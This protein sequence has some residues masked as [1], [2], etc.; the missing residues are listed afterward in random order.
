M[1]RPLPVHLV[2]VPPG[3]PA[4]AVA[5]DRSDLARFPY[6]V[7][8][9]D[10]Y[11][12]LR[13][14]AASPDRVLI[15]GPQVELLFPPDLARAA[16]CRYR[17]SDH[18]FLPRDLY[19]VPDF[20]ADFLLS[21]ITAFQLDKLYFLE[22]PEPSRFRL[23]CLERSALAPLEEIFQFLPPEGEFAQQVRLTDDWHQRLHLRLGLTREGKPG[24]KQNLRPKP[25]E[26]P[27]AS[28]PPPAEELLPVVPGE[29]DAN[30]HGTGHDA[31]S[32]QMAG[33]AAVLSEPG[34]KAL[35]A[36]DPQAWFELFLRCLQGVAEPWWS[37]PVARLPRPGTDSRQHAAGPPAQPD[38][39]R[40]D[41]DLCLV[42]AI[43]RQRALLEDA[44]KNRII[45]SF[46][47]RHCPQ[48][49]CLMDPAATGGGKGPPGLGLKARWVLSCQSAEHR[50]DF[51]WAFERSREILAELEIPGL[52]PL[53]DVPDFL[54][55]MP[56]DAVR[57][58]M[59]QGTRVGADEV[60]DTIA[61]IQGE[62][63]ALPDRERSQLQ[64]AFEGGRLVEDEPPVTKPFPLDAVRNYLRLRAKD[65]PEAVFEPFAAALA[66]VAR[67]VQKG[68]RALATAYFAFL[69]DVIAFF[70]QSDFHYACIR[71][72][73]H[74][75]HTNLLQLA[76]HPD[77]RQAVRQILSLL[78]TS[79]V[80]RVN[81]LFFSP[82]IQMLV[83]RLRYESGEDLGYLLA[84]IRSLASARHGGTGPDKRDVIM[85]MLHQLLHLPMEDKLE[86]VRLLLYSSHS[87]EM[88]RLRAEVLFN[89]QAFLRT[90]R[91]DAAGFL[92][93]YR[94][95]DGWRI[96]RQI[97]DDLA[98][99]KS[100]EFIFQV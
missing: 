70:P 76:R 55:N 93:T 86:I 31:L 51:F 17:G 64:I 89:L 65:D 58:I 8:F 83:L 16:F 48:S 34:F 77:H 49:A 45:Q 100:A 52:Q 87:F 84:F 50:H 35:T 18:L 9:R 47:K 11:A 4:D 96:E 10:V 60:R 33:E 81:D 57:R 67:T 74:E 59:T 41:S 38:P 24:Q 72:V 6:R 14:I 3:R 40:L 27:T 79:F 75:L 63:A 37:G 2:A 56:E 69:E 85:E 7:H 91:V 46:V 90:L 36:D 22:Q 20:P 12:D 53:R 92:T 23:L 68:A 97:R 62:L 66:P 99:L 5:V 1:T 28:I 21:S 30:L 42:N 71:L 94:R 29:V 80:P 98:G 25:R 54:A 26:E 73:R 44:R 95:W 13:A 82:L 61:R 39:A 43:F 32:A 19:P 78:E 88:P 15:L